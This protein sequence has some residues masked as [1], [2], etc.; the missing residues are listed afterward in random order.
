MVKQLSYRDKSSKVSF[1]SGSSKFPSS[2][3]ASNPWAYEPGEPKEPCRVVID[4]QPLSLG[5]SGAIGDVPSVVES[6]NRM[7][8][9][10]R[11]YTY[12]LA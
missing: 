11:R 5:T 3:A 8:I 4:A 9:R 7:L 1:K 6:L 10:N 2:F 12:Y